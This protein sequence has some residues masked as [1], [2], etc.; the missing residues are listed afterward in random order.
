M[1]KKKE[2]EITLES[3]IYM[4]KEKKIQIVGKNKEKK[5]NTKYHL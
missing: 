1:S 5:R 3:Q 4:K 2:K